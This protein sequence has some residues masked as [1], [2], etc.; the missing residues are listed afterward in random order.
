MIADIKRGWFFYFGMLISI[1]LGA[2]LLTGAYGFQWGGPLIFGIVIGRVRER[3]ARN[4]QPKRRS[5]SL[6]PLEFSWP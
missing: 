4:W 1:G 3:I 2:V 6:G 5:W